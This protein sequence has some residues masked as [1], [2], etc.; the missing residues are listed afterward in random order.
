[1]VHINLEEMAKK[2]EFALLKKPAASVPAMV[3]ESS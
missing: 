3:K 1:M 2:Q